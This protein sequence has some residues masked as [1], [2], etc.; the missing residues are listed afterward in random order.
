MSVAPSV[1]QFV[2]SSVHLSFSPSVRP[3]LLANDKNVIFYFLMTNC[4]WTKGKSRTIKVGKIDGDDKDNDTNFYDSIQ[5]NKK[6]QK[7]KSAKE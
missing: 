5:Q 6:K 3:R 2:G 1:G 7:Y 4:T